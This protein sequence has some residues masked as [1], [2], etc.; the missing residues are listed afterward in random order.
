MNG[1]ATPRAVLYVRLSDYRG[2][3]DPSTSPERQEAQTRAYC[4]AREWPVVAVVPDLDVSAFLTGKRLERPGLREALGYIER[5]EA[6]RL[7]VAKLNRLARSVVDFNEIASH[8]ARLGGSV[9]SVA[10]ALDLSTSG[11][12]FTANVLAS[13]AEAESD[14]TRER[15]TEARE[16]LAAA[17]RR[18]G[19]RPPYGY[20]SVPHPDGRGRALDIDQAE[21]AEVREWARRILAGDGVTAIA[22]DLNARGMPRRS[23]SRGSGKWSPSTVSRILRSPATVGRMI[24]RGDVVRDADGHP[25]RVWPEV[26]DLDTWYA[27]RAV[28][29]R[30][31]TD[32]GP[33]PFS[34]EARPRGPV[35]RRAARLMSSLVYCDGCGTRMVVTGTSSGPIYRCAARSNGLN[36]DRSASIL[37]EKLEAHVTAEFLAVVGDVPAVTVTSDS[38]AEAAERLAEVNRALDALGRRMTE[39]GADVV[40]LAAERDRLHE[41]ADGLAEA[42]SRPVLRAVPTGRT[43][44]EEWA[45]AGERASGDAERR[46]LLSGWLDAVSVR[47]IG[48]G[49]HRRPLSERVTL[50]PR[51]DDPNAEDAGGESVNVP[52]HIL[53]ASV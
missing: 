1:N 43:V 50:V 13:L 53:A 38:D 30:N 48:R 22:R 8:V 49:Y 4:E 7:V 34:A 3:D 20:V 27:V 6:S 36:C 37:A 14:Q 26:L 19:T 40:A 12:R 28:L 16:A 5:G 11:G 52:P 42:A 41:I 32:P 39:R 21:A 9:V 18:G 33:G 47:A 35:R 29:D 2:K 31:A 24:H 25:E 17:R 44:A 23:A 46:A 15:V 51:A 45:S 10:E